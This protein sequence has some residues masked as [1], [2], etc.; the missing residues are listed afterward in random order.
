M[1]NIILR[2]LIDGF[3]GNSNLNDHFYIPGG[4]NIRGF[5]NSDK[6]KVN[7]LLSMTNELI[8]SSIISD[9]SFVPKLKIFIDSGIFGDKQSRKNHFFL[10]NAGIGCSL[11]YSLLGKELNLLIDLPFVIYDESLKINKQNWIFS[12]QRSF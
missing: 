10:A 12:F 3:Y 5:I 4:G 9:I 1:N 7:E 11:N 8:F 2:Y 6:S